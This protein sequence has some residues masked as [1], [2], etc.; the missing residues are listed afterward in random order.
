MAYHA[1]RKLNHRF[2]REVEG[3]TEEAMACLLDHDWPGNVREL[4]NLFEASF[5]NL[6]SKK[7]D[8][9]DFPKMFQ[10]RL[11]FSIEGFT[12]ERDMVLAALSATKWNKSEAAKKLQ[13]SRMKVYRTLK[14]HKIN[15][16]G[17]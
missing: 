9:V 2:S 16:Q 1:I 5:I 8:F 17:P 6:S 12:N 3:L 7:N 10:K 15:L 13:W 14:R 4:I 11:R